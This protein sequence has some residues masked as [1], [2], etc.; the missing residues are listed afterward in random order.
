MTE[1]SS[2]EIEVFDGEPDYPQAQ[3]ANGVQDDEEEVD[4]EQ[5]DA[6]DNS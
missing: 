2:E 1:N 3:N 5:G 4:D 6:E